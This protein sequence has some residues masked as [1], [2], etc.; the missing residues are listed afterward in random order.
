ME[1]RRKGSV[2]LEGKKVI[3]VPYMETHVPKYHEWMQ[4]GSLLQA[5]ASEPLT[6]DQEYHMQLSWS[7]DPNKETFIVLDKDFVVGHFSHGEPHIEAMAGDVNIFMNDLDNP[8]MAEIEI[9]IAELKSRRKGLGKESVLMMMAFAIEKF[10]INIFQVKIGESNE[11]SLDLFR[12]LGFVQTSYSNIFKEVT[13]ELQ[14]T[15]PKNEEILG[16]MGT[17]VKHT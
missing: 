15:Q 9:M 10:G 5:T 13:L 7:Q 3:L 14:I 8:H 12:K 16:L 17:L 1:E 6:L 4:D 2:S 11:A